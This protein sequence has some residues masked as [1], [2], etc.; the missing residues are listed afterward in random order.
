MNY[1]E[2]HLIEILAR[3]VSAKEVLFSPRMGLYVDGVLNADRLASVEVAE[4]RWACRLNAP[5]G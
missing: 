1:L 2:T 3:E 5:V 4:R